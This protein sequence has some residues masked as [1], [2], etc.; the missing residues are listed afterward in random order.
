MP[1]TVEL[2]DTLGPSSVVEAVDVL[3]NYSDLPPLW[4]QT[5]LQLCYGFVSCIWFL[6]QRDKRQMDNCRVQ[7]YRP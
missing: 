1:L 2:K 6:E 3:G 7:T 5:S 4:L